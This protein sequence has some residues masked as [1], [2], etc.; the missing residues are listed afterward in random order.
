MYEDRCTACVQGTSRYAIL[1]AA[2]SKNMPVMS[3]IKNCRR[4]NGKNIFQQRPLSLKRIF[5]PTIPLPADSSTGNS[6][7]AKSKH[8][9]ITLWKVRTCRSLI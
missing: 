3:A 1:E 2:E 8:A 4:Q 5:L 6:K 7:H 9:V